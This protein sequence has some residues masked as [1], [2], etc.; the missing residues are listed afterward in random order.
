MSDSLGTYFNF[1]ILQLIFLETNNKYAVQ[2]FNDREKNNFNKVFE[3]NTIDFFFY[4]ILRKL[5]LNSKL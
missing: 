5:R 3:L 1:K 2:N 4:K